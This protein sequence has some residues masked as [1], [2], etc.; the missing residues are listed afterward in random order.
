METRYLKCVPESLIRSFLIEEG[1]VVNSPY[2]YQL[3]TKNYSL[4]S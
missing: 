2:A 1:K 4:S 3:L